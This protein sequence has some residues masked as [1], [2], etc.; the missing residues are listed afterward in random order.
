MAPELCPQIVKD[1]NVRGPV[2][3]TPDALELRVAR[4]RVIHPPPSN[5]P[6][7]GAIVPVHPGRTGYPVL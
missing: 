6:M 1:R 7:D 5:T 2:G 4:S 3:V